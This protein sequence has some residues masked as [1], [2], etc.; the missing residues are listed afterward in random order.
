MPSIAVSESIT[1]DYIDSGHIED[2]QYT[3]LIVLHGHTFYNREYFTLAGLTMMLFIQ[4]GV[5]NI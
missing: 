4:M 2:S 3:T 5:R 1:F